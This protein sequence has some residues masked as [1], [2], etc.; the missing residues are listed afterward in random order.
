MG[1][2]LLDPSLPLRRLLGSGLN[3]LSGRLGDVRDVCETSAESELKLSEHS[4]KTFEH[5]ATWNPQP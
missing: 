5:S 4:V 3:Y 1:G 2:I